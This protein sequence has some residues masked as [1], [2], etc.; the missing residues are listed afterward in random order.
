MSNKILAVVKNL[1]TKKSTRSD[2]LLNPSEEVTTMLL[3]LSHKTEREGTLPN[4]F[5]K[6]SRKP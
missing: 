6:A 5:H 3:E 1:P 2:S 4:T